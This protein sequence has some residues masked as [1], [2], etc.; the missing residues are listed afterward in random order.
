MKCWSA[1]NFFIL[2]PL[3]VCLRLQMTQKTE[4]L[5]DVWGVWLLVEGDSSCFVGRRS[6]N[7]LQLL[8]HLQMFRLWRRDVPLSER[9]GEGSLSVWSPGPSASAAPMGPNISWLSEAPLLGPDQPVFLMTPAA[10]AVSGFFV[11]TALILTSHQVR[12]NLSY[13]CSVWR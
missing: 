12:T 11:W 13:C 4:G 5:I 1:S 6:V 3:S 2:R 7:L 9:P 10:Q 8:C